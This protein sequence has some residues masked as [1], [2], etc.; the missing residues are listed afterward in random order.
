MNV[1]VS[2]ASE[3]YSRSKDQLDRPL[4][5]LGNSYEDEGRASSTDVPNDLPRLAKRW[6]SW[7]HNEVYNIQHRNE[8]EIGTPSVDTVHLSASPSTKDVDIVLDD[9][10]VMHDD[11]DKVANEK[12]TCVQR[13]MDI[14]PNCGTNSSHI[15]SH[16]IGPLL[17]L[18]LIALIVWFFVAV[19]NVHSTNS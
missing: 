16:S 13:A 9:Q 17:M 18:A 8:A 3:I 14:L 12:I 7:E 15:L 19:R 6:K 1:S 11:A 2:N 5:S 4:G 10:A